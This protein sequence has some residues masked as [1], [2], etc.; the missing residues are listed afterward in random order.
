MEDESRVHSGRCCES[1][2][3]VWSHEVEVSLKVD[4]GELDSRLFAAV[5]LNRALFLL[6]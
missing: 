6:L 4:V 3:P 2:C 1:F 5:T